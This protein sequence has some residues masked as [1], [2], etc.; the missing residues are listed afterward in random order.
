MSNTLIFD[1]AED[2]GFNKEIKMPTI[3]PDLSP[4]E[5][6]KKL[7]T[8]VSKRWAEESKKIPKER[9]SE[10]VDGIRFEMD[11]IEK[12]NEEVKTADY[13]L[14]NEKIIDLGVNKYNGTLTRTGRGSAVSF[15]MNKL[16]GFTEIDRFDAE[17]P[18]YPT[19]FIS[20]SRLLEAKSLADIDFNVADPMPFIQASKEI[21]GDD[22]VSL[23]V[24]IT[25]PFF[26]VI[27]YLLFLTIVGNKHM[28]FYFIIISCVVA[29]YYIV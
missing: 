27:V 12:T 20:V 9:H 8:I 11:I 2:L 6:L 28:L 10:Y 5:R 3:Y 25:P 4:E 16:L 22:G 1:N 7:K 29:C 24:G 26:A 17:V 13:F 19:R 15:Y 23:T 18:L 21:L 14:I